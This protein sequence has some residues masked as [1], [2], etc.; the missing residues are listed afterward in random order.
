M[1]LLIETATRGWVQPQS[2]GSKVRL[3]E[4]FVSNARLLRSWTVREHGE[5]EI[6]RERTEIS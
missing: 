3:H 4:L 6:S 2:L 5:L 1:F